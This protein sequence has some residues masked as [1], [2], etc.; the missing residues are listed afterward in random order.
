MLALASC[1]KEPEPKREFEVAQESRTIVSQGM[2]F[3]YDNQASQTFSFTAPDRWT[4]SAVDTKASSWV[5]ITPTSGSAGPA[6]MNVTTSP[7]ST[8]AERECKITITSGQ[9]SLSFTVRQA[10]APVPVESVKIA[11]DESFEMTEG[12]VT[13]LQATVEP[14]NADYSGITW[15][16]SDDTIAAV[17]TI[18]EVTALQEGSAIITAE[19]GGKKA[20]VSVTVKKRIITATFIE[21][22]RSTLELFVGESFA[23]TA[24]VRPDNATDKTVTWS[25]D[26]SSVA[27][28]DAN[29]NVTAVAGGSAT[30]TARCGSAVASCTVLISLKTI[31]V[32]GIT[33]NKTALMLREGDSETLIATV[34]PDNASDKTV[35]WTTSNAAVATVD[36]NGKVTAVANGSVTISAVAADKVATCIV[37]V[38]SNNSTSIIP[39]SDLSLNQTSLTLTEGETATLTATVAPDNA[40]DKTVTWTTGIAAVATVSASGLVT[41]IG[42]GNTLITAYAGNL[43]VSCEVFVNKKDVNVP[44]ES[45]VLNKTTL[46]LQPGWTETLVATVFPENATDKKVTWSTGNTAVVT[47]DENGKV[48]AVASGSATVTAIAGSKSASC[49]VTVD[50]TTVPVTAISLDKTSLTLQLGSSATLAATVTPENATDKTVTWSSNNSDIASVDAQGKV[51]ARSIG[52]TYIMAKAG[53]VLASCYIT[54]TAIPVTSVTLDK[55]SLT[56]QVGGTASLTATVGPDNATDKT[57]TWSSS[58]NAVVFV[59]GTGRITARGVG[60]ATVTA[61]AG[62]KSAACTV[63]V[64]PVPVTSVTL[65]R[66]SMALQVGETET[67]T[68]TVAPD[69]ATDKTITWSSSDTAIATVDANGK[70]SA[71][72]VG[73]ATVTAKAGAKSAAC[74]VTVNPVPVSSVTLNKES[75]TLQ[76]GESET[77]TATVA[78][79]NAT[80]KSVTW[81]S[82]NTDIATVDANGKVTAVAVGTVTVTAKAGNMSAACAVTVNPIPVTS[83]TLN[84]TS[85][86]LQ[87]GE[88][89]T[90]TATVAP[91][92]ATDKTV[93]WRTSDISVASV[94]VNGKITTYKVGTATITA[95]AGGVSATCALTVNPV[96]VASISLD[97]TSIT[98][99]ERDNATLIATVGPDN[100]TDKT[101]TWTSSNTAIATVTSAGVVNAIKAGI[102]VITAKAGEKT[103][104]CTVNVQVNNGEHEGWGEEEM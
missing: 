51:T 11:G 30:V 54:V 21:L 45:V 2:S 29:G 91:D 69:N 76:I 5:S 43:H 99:K 14:V 58:D 48:T 103:A 23:L 67:L 20:S 44:V 35:T 31:P 41:A 39:V 32:D 57:V 36:N 64:N 10:A 37:S 34:Y 75:L 97:R 1:K 4:A 18:G 55:T 66:S 96:P 77:L 84:K 13:Q 92:N 93:S 19:A 50:D 98:L 59:D 25:S 49:T 101:V 61:K 17:S 72:A 74:T 9:A 56:L 6:N 63:T 78:P 46:S 8:Q 47:V 86:A 27:A 104:T 90:L 81:S 71:M 65:S 79:A 80:D 26:P 83:V 28:V 53:N 73:T 100:A 102:A 94:D 62:D 60:T 40:T 70:V 42:N 38:E 12:D 82:S 22:N 88:T 7:N 85:L 24:T 3:G 87:V 16:S 15:S 89:E 52:S 68:A 33:L 95:T